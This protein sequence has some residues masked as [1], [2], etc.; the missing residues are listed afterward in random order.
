MSFYTEPDWYIHKPSDDFTNYVC[1]ECPDMHMYCWD[2]LKLRPA[3]GV[4]VSAV[5]FGI[6][7]LYICLHCECLVFQFI[8]C[9]VSIVYYII[10]YNTI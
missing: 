6:I 4:G 1:D 8:F 3:T 9:W 2:T 10:L 5:D 7:Y